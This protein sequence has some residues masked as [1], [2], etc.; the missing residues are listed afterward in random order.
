MGW[1]ADRDREFTEFVIA[2]RA[3]LVRVATLLVFGDLAKAEDVVQTALTKLYLAWPRVRT[4]TAAAYARRCVVN[5]AM[6]DRRSLFS[7]REQ[8]SAELP[9]VT[10]DPLRGD[11]AVILA[12]L[13]ALPAGMRAAVVLRYVEGL[14]VAETADAMG[15]SEGNVKSQSARGLDRLRE[16]LAQHAR[17]VT[18]RSDLLFEGVIRMPDVMDMLRTLPDAVTPEPAGPDIAAADVA[19]GHRALTR[20]RR[21]RLAGAAGAV[22][23]V[24]GVAVAIGQPSQ[25]IG[26]STHPAA[27]GTTGPRALAIRLTAYTGTQ[28]VG[29]EVATVPAHWQV[30]SSNAFAF[31][32][33][34]PGASTANP[35]SFVGRI[36]VALQGMSQ[37]Q[38]NAVVKTVTI[39]GRQGQLG[40]SDGE[41]GNTRYEWLIYPDGKGHKILI[42]LP[43]SF[44]FT[45]AQLVQ[46]A[47]GITVTKAAKASLG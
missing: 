15:C 7:R 18:D 4:D 13:A 34:P 37:L 28:P 9:D 19:R 36:L 5:A 1:P 35:D 38:K 25:L 42:Q 32:V 14:S 33:A 3:A 6:D 2:Q 23:V 8:V 20:R 10:A 26:K 45:T 40:L 16:A 24:A 41:V 12:L 21:R 27:G 22:A 46:F 11:T 30:V 17:S 31:V 29:F 39:N 43:T 44:G 47:D